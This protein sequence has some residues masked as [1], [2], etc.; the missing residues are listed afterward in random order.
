MAQR[1]VATAWEGGVHEFDTARSYGTSELVLGK[2]LRAL[3]VAEQALVVSKFT[4]HSGWC[5]ETL[6]RQVEDSVRTLGVPALQGMMLHSEDAPFETEQA[7]EALRRLGRSPL[8]RSLGVSVYASARAFT[9]IATD[10]I[11]LV[12]VPTNALDRRF[13][14]AG[15]FGAAREK[16]KNVSIRSIF[17]QGLLL[18]PAEKVA[19]RLPGAAALVAR[20]AELADSLGLSRHELALGYVKMAHPEARVIFGAETPEQVSANLDAWNRPCP[21]SLVAQVREAFPS[22]PEH[23]VNPTHW[24]A[25]M[26]EAPHV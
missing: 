15:V 24:Q 18:M 19:R 9:A 1:I 16:K 25:K 14:T 20:Y 23:I 12:Q 17:L 26:A 2:A 4:S 10:W 6:L 7:G 11:D 8:A 21:D 22:V 3:G 5:A 13:E